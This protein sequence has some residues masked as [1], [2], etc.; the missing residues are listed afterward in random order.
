MIKQ[1]VKP[2]ADKLLQVNIGLRNQTSECPVNITLPRIQQTPTPRSE[3]NVKISGIIKNND[4][5]N[6]KREDNDHDNQKRREQCGQ[7]HLAPRQSQNPFK[8][9]TRDDVKDKRHKESAQVRQKLSGIQSRRLQ[10]MKINFRFLLA[11][12][13]NNVH[14]AQ[15]PLPRE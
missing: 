6:Y 4:S 13:Y 11:C 2:L 14:A 10:K 8:D 12:D 3:L 1:I 9:R 5:K 7:P 15:M